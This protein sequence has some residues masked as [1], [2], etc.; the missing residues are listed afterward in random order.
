MD[1]LRV[2]PL[3]W[4]VF[5][6]LAGFLLQP[7]HHL[8]APALSP[9]TRIKHYLQGKKVKHQQWQR[10]ACC[11]AVPDRLRLQNIPFG[12]PRQLTS[13]TV[14][15]HSLSSK[16]LSQCV[17]P[18]S[19]LPQQLSSL[20]HQEGKGVQPKRLASL[21]SSHPLPLLSVVVQEE[22]ASLSLGLTAPF[23]SSAFHG[24]Y[25]A[26][27]LRGCLL[28]RRPCRS[29]AG[30]WAQPAL[31]SSAS[32]GLPV[33]QLL[34]GV[35]CCHLLIF[36]SLGICLKTW[37]QVG[38]RGISVGWGQQEGPGLLRG[39]GVGMKHVCFGLL[40]GFGWV[41]GCKGRLLTLPL[42]RGL[43]ASLATATVEPQLDLAAVPRGQGPLGWSKGLSAGLSRCCWVFCSFTG[44]PS[45]PGVPC[46]RPC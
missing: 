24:H 20:L 13:R 41:L 36:L 29:L 10:P 25:L 34:L 11:R 38:G 3:F 44:L 28:A 31:P 6:S 39:T 9:T 16:A 2:C 32:C 37:E 15:A 30:S 23:C 22:R 26:C 27:Q 12:I 43:V 18:L 33:P 46:R 4:C 42:M 5:L 14:S 40:Q 7:C 35:I 19:P 8:L 45:V 17:G 1:S 21:C